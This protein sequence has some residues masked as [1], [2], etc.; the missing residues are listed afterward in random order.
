M[1]VRMYL[2]LAATL[3]SACAT[4]SQTT[5][6]RSREAARITLDE[7][8]NP[9]DGDALFLGAGDIA[10]CSEI[11]NAMATGNLIRALIGTY[12]GAKVFTAGDNAYNSGTVAQFRDCYEPAW[13]S[14]NDRTAPAPGNHD[15]RTADALPYFDYFDHYR[16]DPAAKARGYYSFDLKDWHIVSLNSNVPMNGGSPQVAWLDNDLR[17][18][19]KRCT[20]AV[21]HHPLFS[22]GD[23]HGGQSGDP[24]RRTGDLWKTLENHHAD[25]IVNGHDHDYERFA[26]QDHSG[27]PSP[28]GIR[29][30]VVGTGGADLRAF[31][32]PPAWP[33][34]EHQELRHG[35]L[36][37]TLGPNS[38]KWAFLGTDGKALDHSSG[39]V[40]CH[41]K[42]QED[43]GGAP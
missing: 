30:F 14:F 29:Q 22:N 37:L 27:T 21:W 36:V 17:T 23:E 20:L 39:A 15:Y 1:R 6:V 43:D 24:G 40:E 28:G 26:P 11:E 19:T 33:N 34:S 3:A 31:L 38:Y 25:V 41:D 42:P 10:R 13:G 35:V 7:V 12:S 8:V 2:L 32:S 5:S 4:G 16:S 18:T 9:G